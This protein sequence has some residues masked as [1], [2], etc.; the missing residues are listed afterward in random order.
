M[1]SFDNRYHGEHNYNTMPLRGRRS[2]DQQQYAE[3]LQDFPIRPRSGSGDSLRSDSFLSRPQ[4]NYNQ[5]TERVSYVNSGFLS[6]RNAKKK[7]HGDE[8]VTV[9]R[10]QFEIKPTRSDLQKSGI[11]GSKVATKISEAPKLK[12]S[13]SNEREKKG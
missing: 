4:R 6:P 9:E 13:R 11:E 2:N 1:N 3:S 8:N 5:S 12:Q 10:S 7:A